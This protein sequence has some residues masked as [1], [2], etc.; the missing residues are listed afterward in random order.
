MAALSAE[1]LKKNGHPW[2]SPRL[3]N[4]VFGANMSLLKKTERMK[5][6][7]NIAMPVRGP[8]EKARGA[9][10]L[11]ELMV[12]IAIISILAAVALPA[13][14]NY[15][16]KSKFTEV[17]LATAPT[18]TAISTCAVSG[19]CV[20]SG[21]ISLGGVAAGGGS[22]F[23]PSAA[24]TNATNA[25]A[26][27]MAY[28][29]AINQMAGLGYSN[30]QLA[31]LAQSLLD[32]GYYVHPVPA[33]QANSAGN[34][35]ASDNDE[36]CSTVIPATLFNQ[37]YSSGGSSSASV[38]LPC[39]GV[40]TGCSP[41]TKYV[42]SVSY[43][44]TGVITA[45]AVSSSGLASETFTLTPALSAGRVDWAASGTCKTRAGGALC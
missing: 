16:L 17:V 33:D 42:A 31:P 1:N 12:V 3:K 37:F 44:A 24:T 20:A 10:T 32:A 27:M 43:D 40:A 30:A 19:D 26:I 9:F 39:V 22:S 21:A 41:S 35:C 45:T 25:T 8:L 28:A 5:M 6:K 13:Y 38:A 4:P 34:Y 36:V 14:N 2:L 11:V 7:K 18:K 29:Q 23:V 15:T